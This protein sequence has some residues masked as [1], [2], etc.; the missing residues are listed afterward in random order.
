[1][2]RLPL[3]GLQPDGTP[4]DGELILFGSAFIDGNRREPSDVGRLF[5]LLRNLQLYRKVKSSIPWRHSY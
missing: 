3:A 5:D 4:K 2:G 1:M